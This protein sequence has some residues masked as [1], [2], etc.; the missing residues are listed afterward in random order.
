MTT[1]PPQTLKGFRDFL[2]GDKRKRD[3]VAGKFKEVFERFGF[4]PLETPTLEYASLLLGK[5]GEEAD[6]LV[7]TFADRGDRQVGLRY[8]QT[9]PTARVLAQYQSELP[10]YFRRYQIQNVFRADKPQKGRYREFTQCD[11]DIFGSTSPIADAEILAVYYFGFQNVGLSSIVIELN[12]RQTL[13]ENLSP[14]ATPEVSVMSLIQTIDKL[15][16]MSIEE[17]TAELAA[18]GLPPTAATEAIKSIEKAAMSDNLNT[19][20]DNAVKLGVPASALVFNPKIARGLDYYTG[21]IF[22]G[23][24]PEY[25]GGS[26]GGGGRYDNLLRDLAGLEMPAVGFGIGFDRTVEAADQLGVLPTDQT[27]PQVLV[28]IFSEETAP[29]SLALAQRLRAAGVRT[30]VYPSVDKLGKQFKLADQKQIP[31]VAVV[32]DEEVA[33][34]QVTLKNMQSGE[35]R[36]LPFEELIAVL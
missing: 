31:W 7:Y 9:V 11:C 10:R 8:D 34:N 27:G 14:F 12:D 25:T 19:I 26:V 18:K 29:S 24:V 4:A 36:V 35:Q 3:Y 17:A 32:G 33:N 5:Y 28:T 13:I 16:K 6:K 15:D 20:V 2:P 1:Q 30:E 21:L 22:E 23:R